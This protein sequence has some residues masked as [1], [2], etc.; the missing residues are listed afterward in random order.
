MNDVALASRSAA[1]VEPG[2]I[3][4]HSVSV[5]SSSALP[6]KNQ[7][8]INTTVDGK[9]QIFRTIGGA[10][11]PYDAIFEALNPI[12]PDACWEDFEI[13]AE[14]KGSAGAIAKTCVMLS[15][16]GEGTFRGE[17]RHVNT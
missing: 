3:I 12:V 11:G 5:A 2:Q 7:A 16:K 17:G 4:V 9:S 14:T 6:P 8:E 15:K 13:K 1:L 10:G